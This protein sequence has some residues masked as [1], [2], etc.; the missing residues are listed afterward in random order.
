VNLIRVVTFRSGAADRSGD[1]P[2]DDRQEGDGEDHQSCDRACTAPSADAL[3]VYHG[4]CREICDVSGSQCSAGLPV[5]VYPN[6]VSRRNGSVEARPSHLHTDTRQRTPAIVLTLQAEAPNR[7]RGIVHSVFVAFLECRNLTSHHREHILPFWCLRHCYFFY[8][9]DP[10]D[11]PDVLPDWEKPPPEPL[12]LEKPP[13]EPLELEKPPP[14]AFGFEKP[15]PEA[16]GFEKPPPE[17]FGFESPPP[18]LMFPDEPG[19]QVPPL[20]PVPDPVIPPAPLP[21]DVTPPEP[22]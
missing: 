3:G 5:F 17:A 13:P 16:F 2:D 19:L 21:D 10:L 6:P 9:L 4:I 14:E 18:L 22:L 11:L 15:L 8:K 1:D 20:P 7:D 12:E